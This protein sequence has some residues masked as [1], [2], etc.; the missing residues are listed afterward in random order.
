MDHWRHRCRRTGRPMLQERGHRLR[1]VPEGPEPGGVVLFGLVGILEWQ[2]L[3]PLEGGL[4]QPD[5]YRLRR[6][7]LPA[8]SW[9]A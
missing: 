6:A 3:D 2:V 8:R 1:T 5:G 4:R 9:A 7:M